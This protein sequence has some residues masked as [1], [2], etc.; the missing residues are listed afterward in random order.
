[1]CFFQLRKLGLAMRFSCFT[2]AHGFRRKSDQKLLL[3]NP[4][5]QRSVEV[6][7]GLRYSGLFND[8]FLN[9]ESP[10]PIRVVLQYVLESKQNEDTEFLL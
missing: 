9:K 3:D 7:R 6:I 5:Y 4:S 10:C 8:R 2:A 1:M